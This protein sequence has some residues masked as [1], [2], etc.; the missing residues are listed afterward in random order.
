MPLLSF[1]LP[2]I[3]V[4]EANIMRH[5]LI[6]IHVTAASLALAMIF[7]F[8]SASL[9]VE[10]FGDTKHVTMVKNVIFYAI[11]LLIPCMAATGISGI[12]LAGKARS[13]PIAKKLKR[14]PVIALNGILVLIPLAI[15]LRN[16]A[17]SGSF[18]TLFYTL[19]CLELLA[20]GINLVLM[21]L[22]FKDGLKLSR[23]KRKPHP[24]L[25][26]A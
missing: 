8:F 6:K 16:M 17:L 26:G 2:F 19:Q 10:L 4:N 14:M 21:G 24:P 20:G 18:D 12:K 7:S 11:W 5:A 13:G 15:S 9:V 1:R 3:L 23:S 22:N 25:K